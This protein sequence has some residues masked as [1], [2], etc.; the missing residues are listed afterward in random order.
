MGL[1]LIF[2]LL[3]EHPGLFATLLLLCSFVYVLSS[4]LSGR[5]KPGRNPFDAKHVRPPPENIVT[6]HK[7]RNAVLKQSKFFHHNGKLFSK[8]K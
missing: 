1:A 3:V 6:D 8:S 7:T 5:P 4:F 2:S